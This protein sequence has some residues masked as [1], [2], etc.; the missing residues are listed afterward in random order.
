MVIGDLLP[1]HLVLL[2]RGAT[3]NGDQVYMCPPPG[4]IGKIK[5]TLPWL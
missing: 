5:K 2:A 3:S 4:V 1:L